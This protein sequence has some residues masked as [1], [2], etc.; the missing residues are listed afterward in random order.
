M[1][2]DITESTE[3]FDRL[4]D[5]CSLTMTRVLHPSPFSI[6]EETKDARSKLKSEGMRS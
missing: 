6:L 5:S 1:R 4:A 3:T 2:E